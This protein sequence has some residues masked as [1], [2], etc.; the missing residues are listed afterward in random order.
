[1]E[2]IAEPLRRLLVARVARGEGGALARQA[3]A[4]RGPDAAGAA[5]HEGHAAFQLVAR[6]P[7]DVVV[8]G[9]VENGSWDGHGMA[10]THAG[11]AHLACPSRADALRSTP[12]VR[13]DRR[14]ILANPH[15]GVKR[16]TIL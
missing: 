5:G 10:L 3:P 13:R 8:L 7:G 12:G 1:R 14:H 9:D 15:R 2:R 11:S 16:R 6:A 4:D